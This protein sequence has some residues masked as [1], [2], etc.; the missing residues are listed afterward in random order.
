[1]TPSSPRRASTGWR[2]ASAVRRPRVAAGAVVLL[3][4]TLAGC[5][6]PSGDGAA[7]PARDT[8]LS[9]QDG[10]GASTTESTPDDGATATTVAAASGVDGSTVT[11]AEDAP[12]LLTAI[13]VD[14]PLVAGDVDLVQTVGGA[15]AARSY[16]VIITTPGVPGDVYPALVQSFAEAAFTQE[17]GAAPSSSGAPAAAVFGSAAYRVSVG[18]VAAGGASSTVTYVIVP[19]AA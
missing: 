5:T 18:I 2:C 6:A 10:S 12:E 1:M 11:V 8:T 15:D 13:P 3:A 9:A 17:G 19:L 16:S 4:A 14:V 7:A